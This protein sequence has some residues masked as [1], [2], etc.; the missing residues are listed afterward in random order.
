MLNRDISKILYWSTK[1]KVTFNPT[2]SESVIFSSKVLASSSPICYPVNTA[3]TSTN[4]FAPLVFS[5]TTPL[6]FNNCTVK[7]VDSHKHLGVYLSSTLD[8]S[9]QIHQ[10]CLRANRK[11]A[12]LRSVKGLKR[13]TLDLLYKL[14]VRSLVDYSLPLYF[15]TLKQS[16]ILKLDQIQYKAAKLVQRYH[17]LGLSIFRKI[18]TFQTR[19]L[20]LTY[21]PELTSPANTRQGAQYKPFPF[22]GVK[23]S[24]SFFPYFTKLWNSLEKEVKSEPDINIFKDKLKLKYKPTRYKHFNKGS[25]LGNKLLTRLRLNRNYLRDNSYTIGLSDTPYCD[26]NMTSRD[27]TK[28]FFQDCTLHTEERQALVGRVT[29]ILPTFRTFNKKKQL[30]I[31]LNGVNVDNRDFFQINVSLQFKVQTYILKTKRF[32]T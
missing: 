9:E 15:G 4:W 5:S 11:L 3:H 27:T 22:H 10:V 7:R 13:G 17:I 16:E 23:M 20:L 28:H 2:K 26:C 24:N 30:D 31:L 21:K 18:V 14:T 8:W 25:Q 32:N 12:V 29:E 6:I 1:W 19:P